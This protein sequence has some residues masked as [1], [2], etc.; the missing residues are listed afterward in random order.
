MSFRRFT[1]R[2]GAFLG[3]FVQVTMPRPETEVGVGL[4]RI[5]ATEELSR[6]HAVLM[7]ILLAMDNVLIKADGQKEVDV[8]G[9]NM[10]ARM[11]DEAVINHHAKYEE[12]YLYPRFSK[13]K[14][15]SFVDLLTQQHKQAQKA[16]SAIMD[17]TSQGRI[18]NEASMNELIILCRSMRDL[19]TAHAAWEESVL[20]TAVFDKCSENDIKDLIEKMRTMEQGFEKRGGMKKVFNDLNRLEEMCGTND[21]SIFNIR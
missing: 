7:R 20:F 6:E 2:P 12:Q 13:G 19:F 16:N 21:P 5:S 11:I 18:S 8:S 15:A 17:L 4:K 9:I 1:Y 14:F 10:G 3:T